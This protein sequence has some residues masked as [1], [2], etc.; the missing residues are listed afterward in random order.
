MIGEN[1]FF[2]VPFPLVLADRFFHAYCSSGGYKL[3]VFRWD[4]ESQ[5]AVYDMKDS[6]IQVDEVGAKPTGTVEFSEPAE[7]TILY[8]FRP[9]PGISRISGKV[10]IGVIS[11]QDQQLLNNSLN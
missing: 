2:G 5:Q 3:D 6:V 11:G 10:P 8:Q 1:D 4:E 7:G 9:R